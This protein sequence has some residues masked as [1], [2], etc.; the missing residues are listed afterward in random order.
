M[1]KL[2]DIRERLNDP[3]RPTYATWADVQYLLRRID[4]LEPEEEPSAPTAEEQQT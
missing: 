3:G 1:T 2:D 4:K